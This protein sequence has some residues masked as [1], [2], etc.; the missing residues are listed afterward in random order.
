MLFVAYMRKNRKHSRFIT[1]LRGGCSEIAGACPLISRL[2]VE[3][4]EYVLD[5]KNKDYKTARKTANTSRLRA[6]FASNRI[7]KLQ[8]LAVF[9]VCSGFSLFSRFLQSFTDTQG[10]FVKTVIIDFN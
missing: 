5:Y 1:V 8:V 4:V 2:F 3:F 6:N 10:V 9:A 7:K